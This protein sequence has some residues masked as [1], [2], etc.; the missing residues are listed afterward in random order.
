MP[1]SGRVRSTTMSS[2]CRSRAVQALAHPRDRRVGAGRR[3]R[4]YREARARRRPASASSSASERLGGG[5]VLGRQIVA[6]ASDGGEAGCAASAIAPPGRGRVGRQQAPRERRASDWPGPARRSQA[7]GGMPDPTRSRRQPRARA[8]PHDAVEQRAATRI[9]DCGRV[10]RGVRARAASGRA[11]QSAIA[12]RSITS[13]RPATIASAA[14]YRHRT[15]GREQE[16][17]GPPRRRQGRV[18]VHEPAGTQHGASAGEVQTLDPG[19]TKPGLM[20]RCAAGARGRRRRH[21]VPRGGRGGAM[22][23]RLAVEVLGGF[24][25]SGNHRRLQ[26]RPLAERD[27]DRA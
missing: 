3:S 2:T 6:R 16:P 5:I 13:A 12:S 19:N 11:R 25:Q 9:A 20:C 15:V 17:P 4:E 18:G 7:K 24:H 22:G 27:R 23:Q 14:C 10:E 8:R 21:R 26:R 1:I